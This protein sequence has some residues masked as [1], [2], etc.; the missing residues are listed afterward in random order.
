MR[1]PLELRTWRASLYLLLSFPL[2]LTGF[3][4]LV[5]GFSLGLGLLITLIGIPVL[6][7]TFA[8]ARGLAMLDRRRAA[9][10]TGERIP[11]PYPRGPAAAWSSAAGPGSSTPPP[12]RTSSGCSSC[13]R[14]GSPT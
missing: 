4:V 7:A 2:G 10:F 8:V 14:S 1:A 13:S 5:T 11:D 9:V 12:G 6:L 3:V